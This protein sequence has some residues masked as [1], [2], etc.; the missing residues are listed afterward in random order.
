MLFLSIS[1]PCQYAVSLKLKANVLFNQ[2]SLSQMA[3]SDEEAPHSQRHH[4]NPE[5][6]CKI[7]RLLTLQHRMGRSRVEAEW[8]LLRG[9]LCHVCCLELFASAVTQS[10]W[11]SIHLPAIYP[12]VYLW[13]W[14]LSME[15]HI[16]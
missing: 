3:S 5:Y 11:P 8:S 7:L 16:F 2:I 13:S 6:N 12:S 10:R 4:N 15:P 1:L 14:E 9:V